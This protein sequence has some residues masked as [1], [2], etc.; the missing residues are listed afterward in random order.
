MTAYLSFSKHV[1]LLQA[2]CFPRLKVLRFISASSWGRSKESFSLLY[3]A[4]FRRFFTYA[5][6]GWFPFLSVINITKLKRFHR[7]ASCAISGCLSSSLISVLLSEASLLPLRITPT[8]FALSFYERVLR[9][10]FSFP[11]LGLARLRV[12][13]RLCKSS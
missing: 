11:I 7:A 2:K 9:L 4:I 8:H 13:P 1:S 10:P 12:K 6:P 3:K 5:S